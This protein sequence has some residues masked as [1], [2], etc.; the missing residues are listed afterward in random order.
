MKDVIGVNILVNALILVLVQVGQRVVRDISHPSYDESSRERAG[1][2]RKAFRHCD[3]A[4]LHHE[5][6]EGASF[7]N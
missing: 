1:V 3:V 2:E 4:P 7:R 5:K 6:G